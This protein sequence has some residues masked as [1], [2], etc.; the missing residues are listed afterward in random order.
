MVSAA[1]FSGRRMATSGLPV[2]LVSLTMS[3]VQESDPPLT[4]AGDPITEAEAHRRLRQ[5]EDQS[6]QYYAAWW[7]GRMRSQH[8]DTIPLLLSALQQRQPREAGAGVEHNAVARNA[9]RALGKVG[10]DRVVPE[11]LAALA[12]E[13]DGLREAAARALGELGATAAVIPLCER[14]ASGLE[15]AGACRPNSPKLQEPCE[16]LIEALGDI[17]VADE[18]V[19]VAIQPFLQHERPLICSAAARAL[20]QLTGDPAWSEPLLRLLEHPQ[21]QVRRA[22]LM[23]LGAVGWRAAL[24][25]ICRTHA[26]NSLKLIALRGLVE[27]G[28]GDPSTE[29]LLEAMDDLL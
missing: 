14:L 6:L 15:G 21:L 27:H 9:A 2:V 4:A 5:S 11:L 22:A 25:P 20:L 23:D 10:D 3:G 7:L 26:E 19:L 1:L 24:E 17:G 16:A 18:I 12:D 13:D 28:C 8:P 29:S